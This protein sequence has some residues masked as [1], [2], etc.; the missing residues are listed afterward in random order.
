MNSLS[1]FS[2]M[3][4]AETWFN[5]AAHLGKSQVQMNSDKQPAV[6]SQWLSQHGA[7]RHTAL[8]CFP[9]FLAS[10]PFSASSQ[11]WLLPNRI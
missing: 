6:G 2:S 4:G 1:L 5:L 8:H 9:P 3:E 11:T 10:L 7:R